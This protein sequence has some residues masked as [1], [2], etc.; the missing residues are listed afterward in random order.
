MLI[1]YILSQLGEISFV[2][3][4]GNWGSWSA[5]EVLVLSLCVGNEVV[6][7]VY[8]KSMSMICCAPLKLN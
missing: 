2:G 8:G 6:K 3:G 7:W 5:F 4:W 1:V